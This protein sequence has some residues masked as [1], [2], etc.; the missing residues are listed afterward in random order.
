MKHLHIENL[1]EHAKSIDS[2]LSAHQAEWEPRFN[3]YI[4]SIK[5]VKQKLPFETEGELFVYLNLGTAIDNV[6]NNARSLYYLRYLGQNVA[7]VEYDKNLGKVFLSTDKYA[8]KNERDFNFKNEDGSP[9][10]L[11]KVDWMSEEA[12]KFK[13]HFSDYHPRSSKSGKKNEEHRLQNL[14]LREFSKQ[15]GINKYIKFI[16]PVKLLDS[17]FEMPVQSKGFDHKKDGNLKGGHIDIIAAIRHGNRTRAAVI[18]VKDDKYSKKE[19]INA[20]LTQAITY[21]CCVRKL[22]RGDRKNEWAAFFGY[23]K[24]ISIQDKSLTIDV[25]ACIPEIPE[26][27]QVE[28]KNNIKIPIGQD[29]LALGFISY[30]EAHNNLKIDQYSIFEKDKNENHNT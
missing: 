25:I 23:T 6:K 10:R 11:Q 30:S 1:I 5:D 18:E 4:D 9:V 7:E 19:D 3:S 12:N 22:L 16:Q 15:S 8:D 26:E 17:F 24:Q 13:T 28:L 27:V 21:A 2:E 14:L 29:K 20:V